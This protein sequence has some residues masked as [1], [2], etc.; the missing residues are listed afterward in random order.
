MAEETKQTE[1]TEE[2]RPF[3]FMDFEEP[4]L[5][6]LMGEEEV[7]DEEE[8]EDCEDDDEYEYYDPD[9]PQPESEEDEEYEYV[10]DP[11][12]VQEGLQA[13]LVA[14]AKLQGLTDQEIAAIGNPEA[15][16]TIIS[17]LLRRAIDSVAEDQ[18]I[19]EGDAA[20]AKTEESRQELAEIE[21]MNPD[22][23]FDP[24]SAKAIKA[25]SAELN[26]MR[27]ELAAVG[28]KAENVE[29]ENS[30]SEISA[31]FPE[32]LGKGKTN[33]LDPSS[34]YVDNRARLLEEVEVLRAGYKASR[35]QT[36]T[37]TALF[38]K[39]F[40]SVFGTKIFEIERERFKK[41]VNK[42]EKQ[43]IA[44]ATNNRV[45]SKQG[46]DKAISGVAAMMRDRGLLE[47]DAE[48]FD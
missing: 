25:L 18:V 45:S 30:M 12:P 9:K 44:R 21:N 39:A 7:D 28:S 32:V 23:A 40:R 41:K 43:F 8:C 37:D 13:D 11:V 31:K 6:E 47:V 14:A 27:S 2:K 5:A 35:K 3:D 4:T 15:M 19:N 29:Y 17:A 22:D 34:E 48:T 26:R 16:N 1:E 38:E 33:E 20:L 42:R 36:P 24:T 46:R 10:E